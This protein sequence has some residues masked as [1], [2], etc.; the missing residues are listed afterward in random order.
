MSTIYL[1]YHVVCS[2]AVYVECCDMRF[3]VSF[4]SVSAFSPICNPVNCP[5][6]KKAL[7]GYL[8]PDVEAHKVTGFHVI[9]R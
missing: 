2:T 1:S 6:G 4:Q 9:D 8:G 3:L 7:G 5:W